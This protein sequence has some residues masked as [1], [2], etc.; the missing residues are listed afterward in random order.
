ME[1][2]GLNDDGLVQVPQLQ[3]GVLHHGGI[4]APPLYVYGLGLTRESLCEI[5]A[6]SETRFLDPKF[7]QDLFL[8]SLAD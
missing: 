7:S 6:R 8:V 1:A 3:H 2:E 5:L 4:S